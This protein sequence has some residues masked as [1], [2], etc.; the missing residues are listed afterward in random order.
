MSTK[1][2][3]DLFLSPFGLVC[4]ESLIAARSDYIRTVASSHQCK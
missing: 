3:T 4:V 2:L 1:M